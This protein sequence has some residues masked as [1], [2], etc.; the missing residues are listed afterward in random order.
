MNEYTN[1]DW[2]TVVIGWKDPGMTFI[3]NPNHPD[4]SD[5]N[6]GTESKPLKSVGEAIKRIHPARPG[7]IC[8]AKARRV[9]VE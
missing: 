7:D 2:F 3:V 8:I 5:E 9:M 1:G 4:A 6:L